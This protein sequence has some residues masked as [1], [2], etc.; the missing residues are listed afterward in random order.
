MIPTDFTFVGKHYAARTHEKMREVL[1]NPDAPGPEVHYYM[2]RGGETQRNITVW[3][4]GLVGGEYIKTYGHYHVGELDETYWIIFGEGLILKQKMTND[5][6]VVEE[7]SI[8]RVTQGDSVFLAPGYGHLAINIGS[9]FFVTA[10]DSPVRFDDPDPAGLP[11][12]A[13][14]E[15]VR[16]MRG[17]AYYVIEQ[18]GGPALVRNTN[19]AAIRKEDL[20]GLLVV[21]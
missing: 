11:G 9:T 17:F 13:D 3:E 21:K 10:D 1:M 15:P 4:P 12:H 20:A 16:K 19:Y 18:N 6:T 14:Y 8:T 7:F 2:I 5:P